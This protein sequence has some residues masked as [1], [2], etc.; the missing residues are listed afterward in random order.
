MS[1]TKKTEKQKRGYRKGTEALSYDLRVRINSETAA[2]LDE[3]A[4]REGT[5][6]AQVARNILE[7]ELS[8]PIK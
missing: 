2:R 5:T 3:L 6:R 8:K 7:H 4:Q 1:D